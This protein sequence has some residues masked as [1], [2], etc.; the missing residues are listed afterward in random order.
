M[1]KIDWKQYT[2]DHLDICGIHYV[3]WEINS[4]PKSQWGINGKRYANQYGNVPHPI[5]FAIVKWLD[6]WV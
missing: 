6:K 2:R 3:V 4:N 5:K 1:I